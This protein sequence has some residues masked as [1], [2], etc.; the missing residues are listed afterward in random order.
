MNLMKTLPLVV[1]AFVLSY[2]P[3]SLACAVCFSAQEENRT[4]FLVQTGFMTLLP[5]SIFAG[6][7]WWLKRRVEEMRAEEERERIDAGRQA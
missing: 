5:L 2:A 4:A 7:A 6:A 3:E 1:V